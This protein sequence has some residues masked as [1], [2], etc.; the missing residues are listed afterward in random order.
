MTGESLVMERP[1]LPSLENSGT[2]HP[3]A[4]RAGGSG[5][6]KRSSHGLLSAPS[7]LSLPGSFSLSFLHFR[8]TFFSGPRQSLRALLPSD[9]SPVHLV[10]PVVPGTP[11]QRVPGFASRLPSPLA[12]FTLPLPL[13]LPSGWRCSQDQRW[14]KPASPTAAA[15][16]VPTL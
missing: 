8:G 3:R 9:P 1:V 12:M 16:A 4:Q 10:T 14:P 11:A 15:A 2:T 6:G 7:L 5:G 13:A